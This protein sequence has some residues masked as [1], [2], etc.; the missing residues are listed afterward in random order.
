MVQLP[1]SLL[2][3]LLHWLSFEALLFAAA[4]CSSVVQTAAFGRQRHSVYHGQVCGLQCSTTN[5]SERCHAAC[6]GKRRVS[7]ST[8][9]SVLQVVH[10]FMLQEL[11][12][13]AHRSGGMA[14]RVM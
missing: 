6:R 1:P 13:S 12:C 11:G 8:L 14:I 7:E 10:I 9:Q 3:R 4:L 2:L 5:L